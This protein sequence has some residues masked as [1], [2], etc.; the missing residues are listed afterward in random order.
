MKI[1]KLL[2]LSGYLIISLIGT[3]GIVI[4]ILVLS[5]SDLIDVG[6]RPLWKTIIFL[7]V[8][9]AGSAIGVYG[10]IVMICRLIND[11]NINK[12]NK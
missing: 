7:V 8:F 1:K 4:N 5:G 11:K 6:A 3:L 2:S 10:L 9:A 12:E